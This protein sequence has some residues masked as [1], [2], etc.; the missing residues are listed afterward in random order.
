MKTANRAASNIFNSASPAQTMR[1][2]AA[3]ARRLKGGEIIFL[4]GPIGAG[5]TVF[6]Q[7]LAK[8]LGMKAA[9]SSASFNLMREYRSAK[10]R[11]FHIDLFRLSTKDIANLGLETLLEDEGAIIAAE[12]PDPA[13][14]FLPQDRLELEFALSGGDNRVITA[15][16]CGPKARRLI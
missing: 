16:A 7:G 5:K 2:A 4:R 8:T 3:F 13:C 15:K 11:L 10:A 9:P 14:D 6:V 1:L 12:W